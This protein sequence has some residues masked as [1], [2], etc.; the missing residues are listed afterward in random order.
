M[1]KT[2]LILVFNYISLCVSILNTCW[3][4]NDMQLCISS[5]NGS[6]EIDEA[7]NS[8]MMENTT[9]AH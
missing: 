5:A 7:G 1:S 4:W 3:E 6:F 8:Y 9:K 2:H